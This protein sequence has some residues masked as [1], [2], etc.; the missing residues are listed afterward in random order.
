MVASYQAALYRLHKQAEPNGRS[1]VEP[2]LTLFG[3]QALLRTL[4]ALRT[5][6]P[7]TDWKPAV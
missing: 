7:A 4:F 5:A 6:A 3:Q 2:Q 1:Q